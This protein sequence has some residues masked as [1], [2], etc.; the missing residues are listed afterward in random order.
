MRSGGFRRRHRALSRSLFENRDRAF[1]PPSRC[2]AAYVGLAPLQKLRHNQHYVAPA[3]TSSNPPTRHPAQ[4][5]G[6]ASARGLAFAL[7]P[8]LQA[9]DEKKDQYKFQSRIQSGTGSASFAVPAVGGR[10]PRRTTAASR[11]ARLRLP[12]IPR[13]L[14]R[15]S[16]HSVG[17]RQSAAGLRAPLGERLHTAIMPVK[18]IIASS[19]QSCFFTG[20]AWLSKN[21]EIS[22]STGF[23][24]MAEKIAG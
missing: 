18:N 14:K 5:V 10:Q 4:R 23:R 22:E 6:C 13:F 21:A 12:P 20:N 24:Q 11:Q 1:L 7:P 9:R 17:A 2:R 19:S 16:P 8:I 3:L 15:C